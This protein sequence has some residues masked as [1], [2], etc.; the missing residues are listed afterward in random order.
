MS[1]TRGARQIY[2][3]RLEIVSANRRGH[4]HLFSMPEREPVRWEWL[5]PLHADGYCLAG[6]WQDGILVFI[7]PGVTL[8]ATTEDDAEAWRCARWSHPAQLA[9]GVAADAAVVIAVVDVMRAVPPER[10]PWIEEVTREHQH[11]LRWFYATA[12]GDRALD[13]DATRADCASRLLG[14]QMQ[15]AILWTRGGSGHRSDCGST[16]SGYPAEED[17]TPCA[18]DESFGNLRWT[19]T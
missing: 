5:L 7:P 18:C 8:C 4:S 17:E 11:A 14:A 19:F 13:P 2:M 10:W 1:A 16:A 9:F 15:D 12:P 3:S 6:T